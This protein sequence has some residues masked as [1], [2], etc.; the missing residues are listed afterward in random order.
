MARIDIPE[1]KGEEVY[2]FWKLNPEM[3]AAVSS[4]S[5]AVYGASQLPVREREAARMRI[6]QIN[7]CR[8]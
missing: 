3:G 1:G 5:R 8:I 2:R 4:F 7:D 6:A